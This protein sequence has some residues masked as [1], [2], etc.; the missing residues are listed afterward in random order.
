MK[1]GWPCLGIASLKASLREAGIEASCSHFHLET[2]ARLGWD[3]YDILAEVWGAGEALFGALLD[4][5]DA[6]RLT[7]YAAQC[8]RTAGHDELAEWAEDTATQQLRALYDLWID[9]HEA[10]QSPIIGASVGALQLCSSLYLMRRLVER[11]HRGVR[12][13]GGSGLVG[14]VAT[15]LL[16]RVTDVD[17]VI[18]G[19]GET[20]LVALVLQQLQGTDAHTP[21]PGVLAAGAGL[22][23]ATAATRAPSINMA[24]VPL[25]DLDE[26]FGKAARLGIPST[27]LTLSVEHSRGCEW[28]H[29]V[30]DQLRGCTF[31]G[32]Y[33]NS[34]NYRRKPVAKVTAEIQTLVNRHHNLNLAF[35]DAYLSKHERDAFLDG[36]NSLPEDISF[37]SELRCDL[38]FSTVR[39]LARRARQ[40]QLGVESFSSSILRK[41]GKGVSAA[42]SVYNIRI[43]QE[44][45]MPLQYNLMLRI[46]GVEREEIDAMAQDLPALFGLIPPQATHFYL[47]RNSLM[48]MRPEEYGLMPERMDRTRHEWLPRCLGDNRISQ[49]VSYETD[50]ETQSAWDAVEKLVETWKDGWQRARR[51]D[52]P[53]PLT[54][55]GGTGWATVIDMRGESLRVFDLEGLE[56][57]LFDSCVEAVSHNKLS[58]RFANRGEKELNEA[59]DRLI[60]EGLLF[61]DGSRYVRA[62]VRAASDIC[63][64][65]NP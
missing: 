62:A 39:K 5:D 8:L 30:P 37:F 32:L 44:L 65:E 17:Y 41:I 56:F 16:E 31:C 19:E 4:L 13:L 48:Y 34:P 35:V 14:S 40:V 55:R 3:N 27:A 45:G 23:D 9:E 50:R 63:Q 24:K 47:D 54:W 12:V 42:Y 33:R 26:F 7:A 49:V 20:A 29:R 28:E 43:C 22:L 64:P 15:T 60:T 6:P 25:P 21:I 46:P 57:E 51:A 38:N 53:S 1:A 61:R 11:G 2:A 36:L 18:H 10:L 59:L 52:M 58:A